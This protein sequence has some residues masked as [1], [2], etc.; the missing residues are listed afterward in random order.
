MIS[1][2]A[3]FAVIC[4][5]QSVSAWTQIANNLP[6][7]TPEKV[8][9]CKSSNLQKI[10]D[11]IQRKFRTCS[12]TLQSS[13]SKPEQTGLIGGNS[14]DLASFLGLPAPI[15]AVERTF[16]VQPQPASRPP[17]LLTPDAGPPPHPTGR[18]PRERARA[19]RRVLGPAVG[20]VP[21]LRA[22]ARAGAVGRRLGPPPAPR[23][24]PRPRKS[25]VPH[26]RPPRRLQ[27]P[28][29][30]RFPS[31]QEA[32]AESPCRCGR[33]RGGRGDRAAVRAPTAARQTAPPH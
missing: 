11:G 14:M 33:G 13:L 21:P 32:V 26:R 23:R 25:P 7:N 28:R 20:R 4:V 10:S 24:R 29:P 22:A 18:S 27:A 6:L 15:R 17:V 12:G 2:F 16:E 3:P 5:L 19:P 31:A 30:G 8:K 1:K 9:V